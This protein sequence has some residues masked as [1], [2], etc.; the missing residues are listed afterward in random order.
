MP[1]IKYRNLKKI[2]FGTSLVN[3]KINCHLQKTKMLTPCTGSNK[4]R[5]IFGKCGGMSFPNWL[6]SWSTLKPINKWK[7]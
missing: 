7:I 1:M 4:S 6:F 3:Y 2:I 5:N